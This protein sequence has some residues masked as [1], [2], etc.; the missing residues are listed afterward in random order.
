MMRSFEDAAD[1]LAELIE[2]ERAEASELVRQRLVQLEGQFSAFRN[3][4]FAAHAENETIN[5]Q[6]KQ[7]LQNLHYTLRQAGIY[8]TQGRLAFGEEWGAVIRGF[9]SPSASVP[10][11]ELV[12]RDIMGAL[13]RQRRED[14]SMRA[15]DLAQISWLQH[16]IAAQNRDLQFMGESWFP[17]TEGLVDSKLSLKRTISERPQPVAKRPR[18]T[19]TR[20]GSTAI[21]LASNR[22]SS[23]FSPL[24]SIRPS[25]PKPMYTYI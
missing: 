17:L 23:A 24:S 7:E 13:Q 9:R 18:Q 10:P 22:P 19:F 20:P 5:A 16:E 21:S 6:A 15:Q 2:V 11:P 4:A 1:Q 12:P 25:G 3:A 8:Y 14:G